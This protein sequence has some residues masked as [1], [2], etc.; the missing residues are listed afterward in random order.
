MGNFFIFQSLRQRNG[1]VKLVEK[2]LR[3]QRNQEGENNINLQVVRALSYMFGRLDLRRN[4]YRPQNSPDKESD[5]QI[6]RNYFFYFLFGLTCLILDEKKTLCSTDQQKGQLLGYRLDTF[7]CNQFDRGNQAW[8]TE[9]KQIKE[10]SFHYYKAVG[11]HPHQNLL[12]N[13]N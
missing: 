5:P 10:S 9:L 7:V 13:L 12:A 2:G 11:K 1:M 3:P 4:G 6:L 8:R